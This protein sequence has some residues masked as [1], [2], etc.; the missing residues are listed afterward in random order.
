MCKTLT[1]EAIKTAYKQ[2]QYR[3]AKVNKTKIKLHFPL[4]SPGFINN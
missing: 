1:Y 4:L 3:D 2:I